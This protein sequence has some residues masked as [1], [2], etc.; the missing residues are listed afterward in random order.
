MSNQTEITASPGGREVIITREFDAPAEKVW[1]AYTDPDLVIQWMGPRRLK[2]RID[3]WSMEPG[4]RY[5][6]THIDEDGTEYKFHGFTHS[7]TPPKR[8]TRT[9]EFD[10]V[11][12]HVCLETLNL[13]DL[14][15]GRS[16]VTTISVFETVEDRDGMIQSGMEGG[17]NEGNERLDELLEKI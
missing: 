7:I 8:A 5:A 4:G 14:G 3:E 9:F 15:D 2:G 10:G 17:V 12:D 16:K 1:Q 13:E 6:F 11:P